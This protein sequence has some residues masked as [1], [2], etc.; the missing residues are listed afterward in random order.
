[1]N[2]ET[3]LRTALLS[4]PAVLALVGNRIYPSKIPQA[5][6]WSGPAITYQR[7]S[8]VSDVD[9][10]GNVGPEQIRV[11]LDCWDV[12]W[13]GMR[14][15]AEAVQHKANGFS[16]PIPQK[17]SLNGVFLAGGDTDLF[18]PEV[19]PGGEGIYRNQADYRIHVRSE[20]IA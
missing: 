1:V 17:L 15:L 20:A 10:E 3:A 12:T 5:N 11:Q 18:E 16:G 2:V 8:K 14:S 13:T 19:G 4:D 9:L 7:I 6:T